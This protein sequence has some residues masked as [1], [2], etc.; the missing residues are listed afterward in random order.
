MSLPIGKPPTLI[1]SLDRL[2]YKVKFMA[3]MLIEQ[4]RKQGIPI[5]ITQTFRT[6]ETQQEYYSWGR[7]KINPFKNNMTKVTNLDGV[8]KIS[9]HQTG[10]AFDVCINIKGSEYNVD[11]LTK[12]GKIGMGLGL[13]WGGSWKSFPD[14]PH[15]E[16]PPNQ[17]NN[18]KL[19]IKEGNTMAKFIPITDREIQYG[20]S[21]INRLS[22]LGYLTETDRHVKTLQQ[23]PELWSLWVMHVKLAERGEK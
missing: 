3:E 8:K 18:F 17:I 16:I 15:F 14:M 9:R 20:V 1:R 2:D 23:Y 5:I 4:C 21:A 13:T 12:V 6:K 10:L 7:T 22:E 19:P 11:L